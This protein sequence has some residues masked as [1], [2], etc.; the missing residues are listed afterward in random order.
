MLTNNMNKEIKKNSKTLLF[1]SLI[2]AMIL[3]FSGMNYATAEEGQGETALNNISDRIDSL[4]VEYNALETERHALNATMEA[5]TDIDEISSIK[6]KIDVIKSRM[7][8]ILVEVEELAQK[9]KVYSPSSGTMNSVTTG[10]TIE[11]NKTFHHCD[12]WGFQNT[13]QLAGTISTGG[14]GS[15]ASIY[16]VSDFTTAKSMGISTWSG[17]TDS[18]F[19]SAQIDVRNIDKKQ[20]CNSVVISS[21][22]STNNE[23]CVCGLQSGDLLSWYVQTTY[24]ESNGNENGS[25]D[26][27][28]LH[29]VS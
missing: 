16:W 27:T 18:Y 7:A 29:R 10:D 13:S 20:N 19:D 25:D 14:V 6:D 28:G 22:F 17:C 12:D 24:K 5:T 23:S 1:A 9:E 8:Q 4:I 2:A 3:P 15:G 26:W 21:A 11:I